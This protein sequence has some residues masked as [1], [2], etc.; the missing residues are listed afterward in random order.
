MASYEKPRKKVKALRLGND[1]WTN[2]LHNPKYPNPR[3]VTSSC[4]Y[5]KMTIISQEFEDFLTKKFLAQYQGIKDTAEEDEERWLEDLT[6]EELKDLEEEFKDYQR[7]LN[8]N[9][10]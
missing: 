10:K 7:G 3:L 1:R 8:Q 2:G 9:T 5:P 4:K 6:T